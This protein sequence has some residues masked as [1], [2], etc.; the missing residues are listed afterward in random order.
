M[1]HFAFHQKRDLPEL[2]IAGREFEYVSTFIYDRA[3]D[4]GAHPIEDIK[5]FSRS[6][7]QPGNTR[8]GLEWYRAFPQ[9]H[10]NALGWKE[11][12]LAI[13]VLALGGDRSYGPTIVSMLEEFASDVTAAASRHAATGCRRS[14]R[15]R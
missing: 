3:Y 2:L 9:D 1:W 13:P 6:F 11:T 15:K 12:K 14:G 8:G 4:M 5:E 7:A 10:A